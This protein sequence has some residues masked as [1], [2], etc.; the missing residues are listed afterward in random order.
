MRILLIGAGGVGDAI[1]KISAD[2]NFF[3]KLV[4]ADY[5]LVR[6]EKSVA[7][8]SENTPEASSRFEAA[9]IDASDPDNIAAL[10]KKVGATHIMNAVEPKFV[11]S[12]FQGALA[13]GANY[14][15]M[16]MSL[17]HVHETD[18][19]NT[20]AE[21]LGDWQYDHHKDFEEKGLLALIGTGA[22]PGI[23]N[24]FARYAADHLFSEVDEITILDGGNLVVKNEDGEEIF[25]PSFSIWTVI[26]EC[27]NPPLIW[28][29][30]R[31]WYTTKPF[32]E[33]AL[34]EFPGG[35]G[36]IECVNV[37]HEEV[38]MLPRTM[39]AKKVAFKYGL[40]TEFISVLKTLHALG[41]DKI[42]PVWVRSKSG[43]SQVAP[44]DLVAAVLPDPASLVDVMTGKTCAGTL[45]TG[46]GKD[47][48]AKATYLYHVA[49]TQWTAENYDAQAVVWQTALVPVVAL[50]LL[51]TGQWDATG[52]R[53]PEEFD[54]KVF[55]DL[56][57]GEY[58][59]AWGAQGR[60]PEN[61]S[62]IDAN[63]E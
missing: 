41:L 16:A 55:L 1:V 63:W 28:E 15:D 46:K 21:K 42:N 50:E 2:R 59:Q 13:A 5:D 22:E 18:P 56:M 11:Q 19:F 57:A 9:Q 38:N 24:I 31:G 17:S 32:S 54:A 35:I 62:V 53:G 26:E 27:L 12:I 47:G 44:R 48:E 58:G 33:P 39:D 36:P 23:S 51:A 61:T 43:K 6:A 49:D 20:P 60:N 8:V 30:E 34:F 52:V 25:A 37:E 3:E 29:K 7:W 10:A 45:V 14:M 4:V 40:G